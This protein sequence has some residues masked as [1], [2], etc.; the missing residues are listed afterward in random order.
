MFAD[1]EHDMQVIKKN[2]KA[3]QDR[4]MSYIDRNMIFKEFQVGE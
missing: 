2:L 3:T 4:Q 1:M